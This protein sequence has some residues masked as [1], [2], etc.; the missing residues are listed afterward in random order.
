MKTFLEFVSP[1]L[2]I[3]GAICIVSL[4]FAAAKVQPPVDD[5]L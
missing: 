3:V 2:L 4:C 1:F 5:D